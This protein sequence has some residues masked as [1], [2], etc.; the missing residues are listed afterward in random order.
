MSSLN[1][2]FVGS[3]NLAW[4]LAPALDNVGYV[5]REV[6]SQNAKHAEALVKR[7]Y[8]AE[9][10]EDLDFSNSNISLVV[11]CVSDDAIMEVAQEIVLP[12]NCMIVH[13]S[14]SKPIDLLNFSASEGIGV[15][16]PLQTFSKKK[17]VDFRQ[18]P[19]FIESDNS[20]TSSFLWEMGKALSNQVYKLK[21][22]DRKVLH[23]AAIFACNFTNHFLKIADETLKIKGFDL[24]VLSPLIIETIDKAL[25]L[26]P[27]KS[28][29]GPAK[30]HDL[31]VL[32]KHMEILDLQDQQPL[33][34]IYRIVSQHIIDS[35]PEEE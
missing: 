17:K 28:Q 1:I 10:K 22:G 12:E 26:G 14:G 9:R 6:Y 29:T 31:E 35:Y 4:H 21:S 13:T 23:L 16:Y 19:I 18:I 33:K 34:E 20:Q 25:A 27:E 7:L 15:F 8:Q 30:R 5:V 32:D 24:S 3:G 2:A 11:V